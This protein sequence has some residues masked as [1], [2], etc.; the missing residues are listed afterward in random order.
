MNDRLARLDRIRTM[1][2]QGQFASAAK[3]LA[4][5]LR[6]SPD[7][8]ELQLIEAKLNY[9]SQQFDKAINILIKVTQQLPD[10]IDA[11]HLLGV[12]LSQP[13]NNQAER[14]IAA[15]Q[16]LERAHQLSPNDP[17]IC[18]NFGGQV[19][20]LGIF[21]K[22]E[23]VLLKALKLDPSSEGT[24]NNLGILY[25]KQCR[26]AESVEEFRKAV[27]L[28]PNHIAFRN[29]LVRA[30]DYCPNTNPHDDFE[31]LK[32]AGALI[33]SSAP[34][35]FN[36]YAKAGKRLR[37]GYLGST[38][39]T[40]SVAYYLLPIIENHSDQFEIFCYHIGKQEDSMTDRISASSDHYQ[41]LYGHNSESIARRIHKDGI[42]ILI[43]LEGFSGLDETLKVL[44]H[45][46]A[47]V[48]VSYLGW[49]NSTGI[50]SVGY[51]FVDHFTDPQGSVADSVYTEQLIRM[52]AS[53]AVYSPPTDAPDV[54][55]TPALRNG[56]IT[57]GSFNW[58]VKLNQAVIE[59]WA[60]VLNTVTDSKLLLKHT[61][62]DMESTVENIVSAFA[63]HG[64][65]R[66]RLILYEFSETTL[67]HLSCY[68]EVDI[69]LDP[70][71][72][73]GMTTSCEALWMGVPL[74]TLAGEKHL[75]R[76]GVSLL[77]NIGYP[78]WIANNHDQYIAIA[79]ELTSDTG[80]LDTIRKE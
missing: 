52:T 25:K 76:V 32:A 12:I 79:L 37:I 3:D 16:A 61:S 66:E 60:R 73:N 20:Q 62:F 7:D 19:A 45:S 47:P 38:L 18:A 5:A 10:S 53:F 51:R 14:R 67:E 54:E 41:H 31:S 43:D 23:P 74:I 70:F 63:S 39:R 8:P 65:A 69:A 56:F 48:Q 44:S 46:P 11:H 40:H 26:H 77:E 4:V 57:F 33:Q 64:I 71:P 1:F 15:V 28:R 29:S 2:D 35:L 72:F 42:N 21:N 24:R 75:S 22:A 9:V 13:G 55:S 27:K 49:P 6:D 80:K 58:S 68:H 59:L 50:T 78:D 17:Q 30:V 36:H 34:V